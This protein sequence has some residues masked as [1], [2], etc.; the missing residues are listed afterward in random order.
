MNGALIII[1]GASGSGKSTLIRRLLARRRF[2]LRLAVS[3]TTRAPRS[4]EKPGIDYHF[5]TREQFETEIERGGFLE[6]AKVHGNYYGT[7]KKEVLPFLKKGKGVIL[8]IDVQG[9]EQV[10]AQSPEHVSFFITTSTLQVLEERLR[11]RGTETEEAIERRLKRAREELKSIPLYHHHILN[12]DLDL[13]A[14]QIEELLAPLFEDSAGN[15]C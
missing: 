7:L 2:P 9:A 13:A 10:R 11:S 6:Y 3:A 12:D 15:D 4:G 14:T 5:W 8:D 1:S